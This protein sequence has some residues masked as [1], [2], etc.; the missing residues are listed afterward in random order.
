MAKIDKKTKAK[1]SLPKINLGNGIVLKDFS[2]IFLITCVVIAGYY[3]YAVFQPFLTVLILAAILA[4][5][6][7]PVYIRI[8][9][10]LK[11]REKVASIVTCLLIL[12]LFVVPL[13]L[14]F[15]LLWKEATEA[16]AYIQLQFNDGVLDPYIQWEDGGIIYDLLKGVRGYAETVIDWESIDLKESLLEMFKSIAFIFGYQRGRCS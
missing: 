7:F 1:T 3:L 9:K 15:L 2:G 14:F 11:E 5:V 6:F 10:L 13:F 4:T 12:V 8:L 16:Y